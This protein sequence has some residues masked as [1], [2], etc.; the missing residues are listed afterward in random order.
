MKVTDVGD[1]HQGDR[2]PSARTETYTEDI[3]NKLQWIVDFSNDKKV[4]AIIFNGDIFHI[5]RADRNSHALVQG[6]ADILGRSNA[7]VLIVPGNHDLAED[8]LESI[9]SQPIGTL[10]LHPN[11][12]LLMG[13]HPELPV[14]GMPYV[15]TEDVAKIEYWAEK[16]N[17]AGPD[18]Y[19]LLVTHQ[20]I[21]PEA[22]APIYEYVSAENFAAVFNAPFVAYGHIHSR[23]KA[24]AFYEI[25]GTWFCNNGAIS[26]GSL[27][28][29]TVY[30]ELAITLYDDSEYQNWNLGPS[31][32]TSPPN[33]FTSIPLPHRP[34]EE[35][36]RLE[37]V[38]LLDE[39]RAKVDGFLQSLGGAELTYLTTEGILEKA[40]Q[41]DLPHAAVKELE[42]IITNV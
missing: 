39:R 25:G 18:N 11:I 21:F 17:E 20:S 27:H 9:A 31:R 1:V 22:E 40:R 5:K 28:E 34:A 26:R 41:T 32:R 37:E 36:F 30:R 29:E 6:V 13:P 15:D 2:P 24:G 35:V 16:Y 8:R 10:A 42:E 14:F 4:D 38:A 7:P 33:P 12:D 19:P 23:M 3:N